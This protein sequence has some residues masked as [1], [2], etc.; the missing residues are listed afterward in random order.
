MSLELQC[1]A[2]QYHVPAFADDTVVT[3]PEQIGLW[4][5]I[6]DGQTFEDA[7]HANLADLRCPACD[8]AVPVSEESLGRLAMSL[9]TCC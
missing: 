2:C 8:A 9:L 5:A 7:L 1:P 3:I 4:D 6:G